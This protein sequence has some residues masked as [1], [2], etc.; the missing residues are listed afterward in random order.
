MLA[1]IEACSGLGFYGTSS[2]FLREFLNTNS[3]TTNAASRIV[4]DN[5]RYGLV[6]EIDVVVW[7]DVIVVAIS[8][9]TTAAVVDVWLL[10]TVGVGVGVVVACIPT[11]IVKFCVVMLT[12][13]PA[14]L[15]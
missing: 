13:C 6:D 3:V 11:G 5:W 9:V 10:V 4:V 12:N 14:P 1:V 2:V 7:V 15:V 8:S